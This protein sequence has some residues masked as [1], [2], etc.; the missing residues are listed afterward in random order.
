MQ[1][2]NENIAAVLTHAFHQ[3]LR[4][5]D[6]M[7]L[8]TSGE[9]RHA[10]DV[11]QAKNTQFLSRLNQQ[12]ERNDGY[13]KLYS[14]EHYSGYG[15]DEFF[16]PNVG[17]HRRLQHA[18][19]SGG[20]CWDNL[21]DYGAQ[22]FESCLDKHEAEL[23]V[24]QGRF[25]ALRITMVKDLKQHCVQVNM[26]TQDK[27]ERLEVTLKGGTHV[28]LERRANAF[29]VY[30]SNGCLPNGWLMPDWKRAM[31][32]SIPRE[33]NK[34]KRRILQDSD[35]EDIVVVVNNRHE[36]VAAADGLRVEVTN[37][38]DVAKGNKLEVSLDE[39]K[40]GFDVNAKAL[41]KS[42]EGLEAEGVG[43]EKPRESH[44][45]IDETSELKHDV[46]DARIKVERLKRVVARI[47]ARDDEYDEEVNT[48]SLD[49]IH[50]DAFLFL[51]T[52]HSYSV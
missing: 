32:Y 21:L 35:E 3:Y 47:E 22:S 20:N 42:R 1:L 45:G 31:E 37:K 29:Q 36:P 52:C 28:S 30:D 49:T 27:M 43:G 16:D 25:D 6:G 33:N 23:Q 48:H 39:L 41:E 14:S 12:P 11:K 10:G 7:N 13:T 44:G 18:L 38:A 51:N 2:N 8:M 15:W 50:R 26:I 19:G 24:W 17:V 40:K 5:R 9:C 4:L 46:T 34:K